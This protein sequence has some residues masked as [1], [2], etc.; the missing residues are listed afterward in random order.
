M[1]FTQLWSFLLFGLI[2]VSRTSEHW[3][4]TGGFLI[5]LLWFDLCLEAFLSFLF[6]NEESSDCCSLVK[7]RTDVLV[8]RNCLVGIFVS[9]F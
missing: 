9:E 2:C 5:L 4:F 6:G 3:R 7:S 1:C 8:Q